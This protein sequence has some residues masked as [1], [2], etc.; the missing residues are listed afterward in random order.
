[1]I[2]QTVGTSLRHFA[3]QEI[4]RLERREAV[5][6]LLRAD[7]RIGTIEERE[8]CG[9]DAALNHHVHS[10]AVGIVFRHIRSK[11]VLV[12][13]IP[14]M[15]R[16]KGMH[17]GR[18]AIEQLPTGQQGISDFLGV[19]PGTR[20]TPDIGVLWIDFFIYLGTSGG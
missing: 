17:P 1:M 6:T 14:L 13:P 3:V 8:V 11:V 5:G 20:M 12:F 2:R 7:I 19:Q 18:A 16:R 10:A 15:L 4:Q 9:P